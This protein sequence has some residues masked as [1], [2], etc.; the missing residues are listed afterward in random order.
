MR[1]TQ[2]GLSLVELMISLAVGL[3][4]LLVL[5]VLLAAASC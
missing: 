4:V 1:V 2:R 5:L 3:L